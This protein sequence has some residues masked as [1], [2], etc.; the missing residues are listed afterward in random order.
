M[1]LVEELCGGS[2]LY[3]REP[4]TEETA[5]SICKSL[6]SALSYLH[7]RGIVHRDVSSKESGSGVPMA[8]S[9]GILYLPN[10]HI[11]CFFFPH[12]VTAQ[13]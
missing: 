7:S 10:S 9:W 5:Q 8:Y 11:L 3:S 4:Y 2:D 12:D 1:F 6:F 13:V